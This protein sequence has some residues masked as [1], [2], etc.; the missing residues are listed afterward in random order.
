[1][2][3]CGVERI[4]PGK[5]ELTI[6]PVLYKPARIP[7]LC[8]LWRGSAYKKCQNIFYPRDV[9]RS[10]HC[11]SMCSVR[12]SDFPCLQ[13][14]L[15]CSGATS[16]AESETQQL[17]TCVMRTAIAT[18]LQELLTNFGKGFGMTWRNFT[19]WKQT[20]QTNTSQSLVSDAGGIQHTSYVSGAAWY[21][22]CCSPEMGV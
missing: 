5:T 14:Q 18:E 3:V 16:P 2:Q 6:S 19:V 15:L 12:R 11:A 7:A 17:C 8:R 21:F 10:T 22:G 1:M 13:G 4:L 20:C 9:L